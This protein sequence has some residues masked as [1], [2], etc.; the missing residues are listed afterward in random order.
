MLNSL[1]EVIL[2]STGFFKSV[3]LLVVTFIH[4]PLL[5]FQCNSLLPFSDGCPL[6]SQIIILVIPI[7]EIRSCDTPISQVVFIQAQ[8]W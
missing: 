5:I 4:H 3:S 2:S 7:S 8:G 6:E 1:S